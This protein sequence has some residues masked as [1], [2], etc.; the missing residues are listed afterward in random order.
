MKYFVLLGVILM[1]SLPV[2]AGDLAEKAHEAYQN[3]DFQKA[4]EYYEQAYQNDHDKVHLENALAAYLSYAFDL[5]ND[6]EYDQAIKYCEKILGM[7]PDNTHAKELLCEVYYSRGTDNYYNGLKD[8]ALYDMENS[9]KYSVCQDQKQRAV[10]ELRD[11]KI[12]SY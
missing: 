4:G 6:K 12:D 7:Q 8:K 11:W 2:K 10:E 1:L 5:S 3:K 9:Y